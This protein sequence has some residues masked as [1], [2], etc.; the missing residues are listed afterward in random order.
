MRLQ[1]FIIIGVLSGL[2]FTS[3]ALAAGGTIKGKITD[4]EGEGIPLAQVFLEG[5]TL[6]DAADN[7]GE[8]RIEN[9]PPG[10]YTLKTRVIGYRTQT[11]S[12][13]VST[14]ETVTQNFSLVT[15][16]LRMDEVVSTATRTERS[17]REATI[18][19]TSLDA[20]EIQDLTT[21]YTVADALAAI[22][23]LHGENGG[24]EVAANVF[25]RGIPAGGQFQ[26]QTFQE[27]GLPVQTSINLS[28]QDALFRQDLNVES[29]EVVKGG[30]STIFG[31]NRP[32]GIINY[33]TKTGGPSMRTTVQTTLAE[34]DL[35]RVD[36]NTNG[37]LSD[38]IRFNLGGFFRF[39][40]GPVGS[41]LPTKGLQFKGNV[42]RLFENGYL[43]F[44]LKYM[45]D[46][47]QFFLPI[48]HSRETGE[49][50]IA[51]DG[52]H[53]TAEAADFSIP[54]PD[55]RFKS[56][57]ANGVLTKGPVFTIGFF[58]QFGD[59]W[60]VENKFRWSDLEHQFNIFIPRPA[61]SLGEFAARFIDDPST[62][63][64]VYSFTNS[65]GTSFDAQNV[66]QQG[67][68]FRD[69]PFTEI[70]NEL[71]IR[72]TLTTESTEHELI[73]G[74]FTARTEQD[75]RRIAV[76]NLV[77]LADKPRL[78]DLQIQDLDGNV[79]KQ[80]TRNGVI[81]FASAFINAE[82]ATNVVAL[83]AGDE[84]AINDR[85]R[86]DLGFRWER[87]THN[88][89]RENTEPIDIDPTTLAGQD[90]PWG[91]GQFT[92]RTANF[93]EWAAAGGVNYAFNKDISAYAS[94]SRG[95]RV[96]SAR[97][98][99]NIARDSE[100]NFVQ[101]EPEENELFLQAEGGL[102]LSTSQVGL[103]VAIY[104]VNIQDR[105][106]QDLKVLPDGS[107]AEITNSVGETRTIGLEATGVFAPKTIRGL[108]LQSSLTLQ[109]HEATDFVLPQPDGTILDL[110]GND[111]KRIP[112]FMLNST[113]SYQ[114]Y[115]FDGSLNWSH[116]GDKF[117]DDGNLQELDQ[118]DVVNLTAGYTFKLSPTQNARFG[119]SVGNILN[120]R[121]LT[122]GDPRLLAGQN[123]ADFPFFNARP[124]LP[125]R[126]IG[127]VTYNF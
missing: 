27:D 25:V 6:G 119:I 30:N 38:K 3:P 83:F 74:I 85:W 20:K 121:G 112:E 46:K 59:D 28:A 118:F 23:G 58:N 82:L 64:A 33:R 22:P 78:V 32:G 70:A 19:I 93:E 14:D 52:T 44:H 24:G 4:D 95:F 92:R 16:V 37:P 48:A 42:T 7:N 65:P 40:E 61:A 111:I 5:T 8:Y 72:K 69:R 41:G 122:E 36:F 75:Q 98:F 102:K 103:D 31:V 12:V 18:S 1:F 56:Q 66:L 88:I 80:V 123:P 76:E 81:D 77:E 67:A 2:L 125:R 114:R 120:S 104:W 21:N 71:Q 39:D 9:I 101:A 116:I 84:I 86:V 35:Y 109:D 54:T 124:I 106:Q 29:V 107:S 17:L 10:T 60:T 73:F 43:R 94:G 34:N 96:P 45:D 68:W 91:N 49:P 90:V 50:A 79:V 62:Q 127:T 57:M 108:R 115:G 110:S 26:F 63:R 53:N 15:D 47:V 117:A 13:T 100:G 87:Q 99:T 113:I 51:E 105:L 97:I 126:V 11:V 55:G 89:Q